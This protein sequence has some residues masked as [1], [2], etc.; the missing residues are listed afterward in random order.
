M[1]QREG[2]P[3]V[4]RALACF[5]WATLVAYWAFREGP[6]SVP[7]ATYLIRD[8]SPIAREMI[9]ILFLVAILA[10]GLFAVFEAVERFAGAR[11][12]RALVLGL[13]ASLV[14]PAAALVKDVIQSSGV[15]ESM[16]LVGPTLVLLGLLVLVGLGVLVWQT[17]EAPERVLAILVGV[18][19]VTSPF[20]ALISGQGMLATYQYNS[21]DIVP[22][23]SL[24]AGDDDQPNPAANE[25]SVPGSRVVV[26]LFDGLD[27]KL[28][29]ENRPSHISL[30]H[31]DRLANASVNAHQAV[32]PTHKTMHSVPS[33]LTGLP[34]VGASPQANDELALEL[35]NG[36][37]TS[38]AEE[39]TLFDATRQLGGSNAIAGYYHPY[40][41]IVDGEICIWEAFKMASPDK[42]IPRMVVHAGATALDG[43]PTTL[44]QHL[45]PPER[46]TRALDTH[47]ASMHADSYRR[48]TTQALRMVDNP[49]H[50]LVYVH[51]NIPHRPA[52]YD[53]R[54]ERI[55]DSAENTYLDNL[56]LA[57]RT[58]QEIRSEL[59][60]SG[61]WNQTAL[62]FL[63]DHGSRSEP[64]RW[65]LPADAGG[66]DGTAFATRQVPFLVKPPSH[67]ELPSIDRPIDARVLYDLVPAL[68]AGEIASGEE[69]AT[70]IEEQAPTPRVTSELPK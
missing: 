53:A 16:G 28:A 2:P 22:G 29:F 59:V 34:L 14:L 67:G 26:L 25:S 21:L 65:G 17:A 46:L 45:I 39:P 70:F 20:G 69:I 24:P 27:R 38:L 47:G 49:A 60:T 54:S 63:S 32:S 23:E 19:V 50:D 37:T 62:V 58:V 12:K 4:K 7:E 6:T 48:L 3:R 42:S 35:A 5:S 1:S 66:D 51:L 40:C 44:S 61:R 15:V 68:L 57:D 36:T 31:L 52:I 43:L 41:R 11:G 64:T 30:P 13:G 55:D 9:A 10:V 8:P 18:L 33:M 56:A